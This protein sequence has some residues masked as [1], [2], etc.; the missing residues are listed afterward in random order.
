MKKLYPIVVLILAAAFLLAACAPTPTQAPA[1]TQAPA[2]QAPPTQV[3]P[4]ATNTAVPDLLSTVK[5]R[6]TLVISTDPAYPPQSEIK[7]SPQRTAGTKC[8]SDQKTLGE[9]EGFDIDVAAAIAKG[10]GVE[11]CWVTPD[12]TLITAGGWAGRW[13]ISVG[14]MTITPERAKALYFAQPYYTTPAA[15]FVYKTNTTF[16]TPADL[17]G[18]KVGVCGGCTYESFL[19]G[20]LVLPGENINF[21]VKNAT[22]KTYDTDTT[23]LSDL[24]LGDGVRLSAVITAQ[25][26]GQTEI[27]NGKP[28]KQLGDPLYFEYLAPAIDRS[29]SLD[30]HSFI[31]AVS[32]VVAGLH[33]DGTLSKLCIQWE[34]TDL[35]TAAATFDAS[36]FGK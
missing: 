17:S 33:K 30:P 10:L 1:A 19:D 34:G 3:P 8:T 35:T 16:A 26:T 36:Q 4:T 12:W 23:A 21:V 29:S 27:N 14:S 31:A 6:G 28:L 5:A 20:S 18:Q 22:I 7:A 15:M 2:T 9:M 32:Q 11:P 13:D 24:E 25:P